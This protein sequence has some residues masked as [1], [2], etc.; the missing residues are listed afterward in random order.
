MQRALVSVWMAWCGATDACGGSARLRYTRGRM[1]EAGRPV[2]R[3]IRRVMTRLPLAC[4]FGAACVL[5]S[6]S[7]DHRPGD[8]GT[9]GGAT[10][11]AAA[12]AKR[13]SGGASRADAGAAR[14]SDGGSGGSAA[15]D[16]AAARDASSA[17]TRDG[18]AAASDAAA[19]QP[20]PRSES[21]WGVAPSHSS[22]VG[23]ASWAAPI[24]ETGADWIRGFE[25]AA[26]ALP[27][28]ASNGFQVAGIWMFSD[29]GGAQTFPVNSLPQF[30]DYVTGAIADA[31]SVKHWEVWNEP[32]NFSENKS[33]ADY[34]QI[35]V[36]AYDAAK[37][38]DPSVQVGLAAQSVNLNF[39]AQALDAGAADHFDYVTVHPYETL[40]LVDDGWEAQFMSIVPA[41]R[42]LLADK[43]PGKRGVPVW[44]TELGEPVQG[45][46]TA[47]HQ[48]D[49]LV[50]AYVLGLAQGALRIHWFE[51][52]DGDSGPFGLIGGGDGSAPRRPS[53]T[54]LEALI[55]ALGKTPAYDGWLLLHD[56]HY[57]FVFEGAGSAVMVAWT[58]QDVTDTFDFGV[59]VR[60]VDLHTGAETDADS[61][62]LAH[63]PLLIR[64]V[65]APLVAQARTNA[66][67]LL[68]WGGDFSGADEVDYAA[69]N[70]AR[71]LHPLG[72]EQLVT[73]DGTM[74]RD[75]SPGAGVS[76]TV[77][78]AF[79]LY[80]CGTLR[81]TAVVRRNGDASAG[82][83]LKYESTAGWQGTGSWYDVPG[84]DR[85]YTQSWTISDAQFVGKW[86]YNFAF[87]SDSTENS[88]YSL[89]SVTV[90]KQ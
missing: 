23:I 67:K 29:P 15:N 1:S 32:P 48:A 88:A 71:G 57:A 60:S 79:C 41:I 31:P 70:G 54:A 7:G 37:A 77:D 20:V 43:D 51:P 33:P 26:S 62:A 66:G 6:C 76:F 10:D 2:H 61:I 24:A 89:K 42:M 9:N 16:A 80:A 5:A 25:N 35:V 74:A 27:I 56:A 40:G 21:P 18:G 55:G 39:L 38:A 30:Q 47:E 90:T 8:A 13:D 69:E 83:N 53:F 87:D 28:A 52:L 63:A 81:I 22:S 50:K 59:T 64:G 36:A 44:F 65:P 11:G 34:A 68:P 49:T 75:V 84:S 14:G 4:A 86:G 3:Y 58:A 72:D 45:A 17:A 19:L 73:I 85:W 12:D 78:P 82:F 46:I